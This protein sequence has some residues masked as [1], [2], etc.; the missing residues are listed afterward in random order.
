MELSLS[1]QRDANNTFKITYTNNNV[2]KLKQNLI[3]T[4]LEEILNILNLP[5]FCLLQH[6][7]VLNRVHENDENTSD[8][9][10]TRCLLYIRSRL[11]HK[12]LPS[13]LCKITRKIIK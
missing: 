10:Y 13:A 11:S 6:N 3:S 2:P 8:K 1:V 12:S 5:I 9:C 7:I 4:F